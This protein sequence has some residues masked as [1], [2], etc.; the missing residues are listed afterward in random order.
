VLVTP[1]TAGIAT[2][3]E[4]ISA[5]KERPESTEVCSSGVGTARIYVARP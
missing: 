4:L 3:S 2:L 5:A 1:K